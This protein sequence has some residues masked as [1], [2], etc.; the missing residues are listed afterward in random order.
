MSIPALA[1]HLILDR[2]LTMTSARLSSTMIHLSVPN[3]NYEASDTECSTVHPLA[4]SVLSPISR[5]RE[6][7]RRSG[8]DWQAPLSA[9]PTLRADFPPFGPKTAPPLA[10]LPLSSGEELVIALKVRRNEPQ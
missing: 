1:E 9:F 7:E 2:F 10:K 6:Q 4:S 5:C 8:A 3:Q